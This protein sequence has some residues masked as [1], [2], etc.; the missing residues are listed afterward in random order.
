M[1]RREWY[2]LAANFKQ[3]Q[4]ADMGNIAGG[5]FGVVEVLSQVRTVLPLSMVLL[6]EVEELSAVLQSFERERELLEVSL[7]SG[8]LDDTQRCGLHYL[9]PFCPERI[10]HLN[11]LGYQSY[12]ADPALLDR[13]YAEHHDCY[14]L[15]ALRANIEESEPVLRDSD[16]LVLDLAAIRGSDA[17]AVHGVN[18]NGLLA[19]EACR[20]VRYAAMNDRLR[21]LAL[22]NYKPQS[23]QS[24]QTARLLAQLLWFAVEGFMQ[25][26]ND[27]PPDMRRWKKY[28]V[29]SRWVDFPLT[30]YKSPRS[31]RW[32]FELPLPEGVQ[33]ELLRHRLVA[34]SYADYRQACEGELPQRLLDAYRRFD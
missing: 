15:S 7:L 20:M 26:K 14:R 12:Y 27:Y 34:C 30:F 23:D 18:A 4:V 5:N 13:L 1:L 28:L 31:E 16:V 10:W 25:R 9:L 24:L 32:W 29:D 22:Y 21:C 2:E 6:G 33:P 17:P 3:G 19:E 8:R 11:C